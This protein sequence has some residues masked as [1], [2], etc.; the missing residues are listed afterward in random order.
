MQIVG[1]IVPLIQ[2]YP[3]VFCIFKS[4]MAKHFTKEYLD[5]FIGKKQGKLTILSYTKKGK[6]NATYFRCLCECGRFSE[7]R[8]NHLFNDKQTTCGRHHK[9]YEDSKIGERLYAA[10]NRMIRRC[11]NPKDPKYYAYG[12][13]GISVCEE[14]QINYEAFYK[15]SLENGYQ[16]GLWIERIDNDGNYCPDN[17]RWTTREEQMNN[18]RRNRFICYNQQT[19][20]L[21]QWCKTL[22]LCYATVNSRLNRGWSIEKSFET[23]TKKP[24][25]GTH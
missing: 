6:N 19:K 24:F 17:C 9:K 23:P 12:A 11:N 4:I 22:D 5:S 1:E 8:A 25:T 18:T 15:W 7:I 13:R 2:E 10:W 21:A 3:T 14:W 16:I 20:T